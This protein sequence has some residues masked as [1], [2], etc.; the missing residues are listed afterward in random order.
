MDSSVHEA[1]AR[2]EQDHWWY[3]GR[4]RL[5]ERIVL[6]LGLGAESR[7]LEVGTSAGTNLRMLSE[8]GFRK[9]SGIDVSELA[10]ELCRAKG[11]RDVQVSD[12]HHMPFDEAAFDLVL[13]TDVIEHLDDDRSA[14]REIRRVVR[15]GGYV[16]VSVPAFPSLWG[17]QDEVAHHKR[18]YRLRELVEVL[19]EAELEPLQC[20]HFNYLLFVPI[21]LARRAMRIWRP[22]IGSESELNTPLLNRL[23]V[24]VF[25]FDVWTAPRLRPAFGVSLLGLARRR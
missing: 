15:P 16:L 17:F 3:V 14:L 23:L 21:W 12:V 24:K 10:V 25:S 19:Q 22:Q 8:A 11:F 7:V 13:A 20:F 5:F 9:V 2:L 18:R 1:D 4:R 6:R